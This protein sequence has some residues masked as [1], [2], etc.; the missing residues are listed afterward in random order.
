MVESQPEGMGS[1]WSRLLGIGDC[2]RCYIE[3]VA[4]SHPRADRH[5]YQFKAHEAEKVDIVKTKLGD[6]RPNTLNE[7]KAAIEASWASITP[8]Q[9]HRLIASMLRRI[10][11]VIFAKGF[12]TKY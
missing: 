4:G 10:E 2:I 7:L 5:I 8:Q 9:C 6:A 11:A 12:P 1:S 3:E